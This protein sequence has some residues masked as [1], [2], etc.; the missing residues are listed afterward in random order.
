MKR[1][2]GYGVI[3]VVAVALATGLTEASF[4]LG[5]ELTFE[6]Y[7]AAVA[8]VAWLCGRRPALVAAVLSSALIDFGFLSFHRFSFGMGLID[9][10]RL[11]ER[12]IVECDQRLQR[13]VGARPGDAALLAARGVKGHE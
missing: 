6:W 7:V 13:R 8:G 5:A 1:T 11:D 9:A 12:R 10:G 2:V 4:A 3:V